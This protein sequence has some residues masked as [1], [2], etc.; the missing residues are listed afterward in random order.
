MRTV[1]SFLQLLRHHFVTDSAD[2][3]CIAVLEEADAWLAG[4]VPKALAVFRPEAPPVLNDSGIIAKDE[5]LLMLSHNVSGERS[6]RTSLICGWTLAAF[7]QCLQ[8]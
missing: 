2:A 5:A 7:R 8:P 6:S 3:D 1:Q 4:L